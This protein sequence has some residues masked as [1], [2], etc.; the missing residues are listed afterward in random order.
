MAF[1]HGS[2]ASFQVQDAGAT[3]RDISA[4]LTSAGLSRLADMAEVSALGSTSKAYIPGMMDG[5]IPIEGSF[6]PTVDG[7]LAGILG[8][9]TASNFEYYPAGT[10]VGATKP[11]YS[12]ACYLASYD[13]TTGTD[14]AAQISGELQIT[15]T[16]ARAVA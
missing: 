15:G 6:D 8:F 4:Y 9:A 10:P 12:G 5:T 7:Y 16:V 14:G 3:L 11:K 2:K 13:I 1:S